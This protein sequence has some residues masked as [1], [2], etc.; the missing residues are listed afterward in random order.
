MNSTQLL[1][2]QRSAD[3][4]QRLIEHHKIVSEVAFNL[5]RSLN[6]LGLN[7]D[8]QKAEIMACVHD[9]GKSVAT[10]ELSG[11]GSTH[12]QLGIA[13]CE[14]FG[15]D[16]SISKICISHSSMTTEG[17]SIE[18][19]TVR[20][21]DKLW[22]GKRDLDFEKQSISLF[23]NLL[24]IDEWEVFSDTDKIFESVAEFGHLRLEATR[25]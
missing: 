7:I 3:F 4:P 9:I 15:L 10:N 24:G 8:A 13:V 23:S 6:S 20:L 14:D 25:S 21:A 19:I 2:Q 12:E 5:A 11:S 1:D 18:E 17:L 22:K 16:A